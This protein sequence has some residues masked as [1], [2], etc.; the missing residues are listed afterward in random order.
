MSSNQENIEARLAAYVD[1]ELRDAE[2]E[3]IERHLTAN[4]QH[5][6]LIDELRRTRSML[7]GLPRAKAPADILES[8][9]SQLERATLLGDPE[10][11]AVS[12]SYKIGF[13][14]QFRAIAAV[15]LLTCGLAAVVYYVLPRDRAVPELAISDAPAPPGV[16]VEESAKP[17][18]S[19]TDSLAGAKGGFDKRLG[20]EAKFKERE[21]A[22]ANEPAKSLPTPNRDQNFLELAVTNAFNAQ[23]AT[24]PV[25]GTDPFGPAVRAELTAN[26]VSANAAYVVVDTDNADA[27]NGAVVNYL[28]ENRAMWEQ[29]PAPLGISDL[30]GAAGRFNNVNVQIAL[31][32]STQSSDGVLFGGKGGAMQEDREAY[33]R[34]RRSMS[35]EQQRQSFD[36]DSQQQ[37]GQSQLSGV[38]VRDATQMDLSPQAVQ[39]QQRINSGSLIVARNLSRRQV[40]ELNGAVT[41]TA[42]RSEV[43]APAAVQKLEIAQQQ[44]N[45]PL[46]SVSADEGFNKSTAEKPSTQPVIASAGAKVVFR[47]DNYKTADAVTEFEVDSTGKLNVPQLGSLDVS[48]LTVDEINVSI[49]RTVANTAPP[50]TAISIVPPAVAAPVT[51][52]PVAAVDEDRLDVVIVVRGAVPADLNQPAANQ[53]MPGAVQ[54]PVDTPSQQPKP[55]VEQPQSAEQAHQTETPVPP[56]TAPQ[57]P[58]TQ[59]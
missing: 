18:E 30:A 54:T 4:P 44:G 26:G 22:A 37:V 56:T 35:P 15:L 38:M 51:N 45:A 39:Q 13:W 53:M 47:Y 8:L 10:D 12:D 31:S 20:S 19:M 3:E 24:V 49:G 32:P 42:R 11:H 1:D 28:A 34:D 57:P 48:N 55:A 7:V 14:S 43:Y 6:A 16:T 50:M 33:A 17:A 2:R 27:T 25:T 36:A 52:A 40:Q 41:R 23:T 9:Q 58:A 5:R 59:P 21:V 46:A 29:M